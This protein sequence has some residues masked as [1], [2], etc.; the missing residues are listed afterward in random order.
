VTEALQ[1][2]HARRAGSDGPISRGVRSAGRR[3]PRSMGLTRVRLGH[4]L[5]AVGL[6]LLRLGEGSLETA[7]AQ[8]QITPVARLTAD[9][10]AASSAATSPAV[11]LLVGA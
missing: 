6:N 1:A 8:T 10:S 5:P 11:S 2:G 3:R 7:R 9:A 4:L